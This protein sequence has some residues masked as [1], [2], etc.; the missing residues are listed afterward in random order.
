MNGPTP[1]RLR[2]DCWPSE[3][4]GSLARADVAFWRK[5]DSDLPLVRTAQDL[6]IRPPARPR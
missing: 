4:A 5:C 6:E 2:M 3:A 1:D